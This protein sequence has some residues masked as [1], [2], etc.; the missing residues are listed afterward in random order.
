MSD[1]LYDRHMKIEL[2]EALESARVI[3]LI[4]PR[5]VGKTTLVRDMLESGRF[6]S[7]DE[8]N[9]LAAL[10]ADPQGQLQTFV[11][12]AG[13]GPVIIDEVQ[14]SKRL[15][16]TIKRIVD[17]N[18][19][20]GQFLLTGSSNVFISAEVMDSLAGR[21]HTMKMLPLSTAETEGAGPCLLL[22]WAK[23][24]GG[25]E[26]LPKCPPT[27]RSRVIDQV[28][29]GGYPEMR[30]LSERFRQRRYRDYVESIVDR[31]VADVMKIRRPDAMR[32]LIDQLAVRTAGEL[33]MT[34]LGDKVGLT[35]QVVGDYLDT[36]ERLSL[37][38]RLPAWTSGEAGRDIRHPKSHLVD[39]G[40]AAALR[41][42]TSGDFAAGKDQTPIGALFETHVYMELLK[43]LP[44]QREEWRLFHWRDQRGREV[45]I[46]AENGNTLVGLEVKASVSIGAEDFRNF[47]YFRNG[48]AAKWD[49]VGVLIYM[50]D[51]P[52]VFGDQLFA[53]PVSIF[54]SFPLTEEGRSFG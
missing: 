39:S 34:D 5:Q 22:D 23:G 44:Y 45:D 13:G 29:R 31:D 50:G 43:N 21:V 42:L 30:S 20:K 17:G 15:A 26:T 14:R 32:K 53:L 9:T 3:N 16:L 18:R 2:R 49:F 27:E 8:E 11:N 46:L 48:P 4:G 37:I 12:E 38:T 41:G 24:K 33:N 28:L 36:L 52:L 40:I 47:H 54:G 25:L 6:I 35:R 10:E 7:L 1:D 51:R 19:R